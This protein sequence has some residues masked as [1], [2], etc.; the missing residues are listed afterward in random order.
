M[1]E[2]NRTPNSLTPRKPITV[3]RP[4]KNLNHGQDTRALTHSLTHSP[5]HSLTHAHRPSL[6]EK[7]TGGSRDTH[8]THGRT[9]A[10]GRHRRT[11]QPSKPANTPSWD[12]RATT[13][14][15]A[16]ST[17]AA[18]E[19]NRIRG[20]LNSRSPGAER[21]PRPTQISRLPSPRRCS[22]WGGGPSPSVPGRYRYCTYEYTEQ[23]ECAIHAVNNYK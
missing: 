12:D 4:S 15:A 19:P 11:S 9:R 20:R 2:P 23:S 13:E 1:E 21:S 8:G 22:D 3:H 5:T 16:V 10:H 6:S 7:D 18:P 17:A 14:S